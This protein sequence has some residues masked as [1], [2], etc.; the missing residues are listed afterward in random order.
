LRTTFSLPLQGLTLSGY[1]K[2]QTSWPRDGS[3]GAV[4]VVLTNNTGGA[5]DLGSGTVSV[6]LS[7]VDL[8]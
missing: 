8:R 1:V 6:A 7:S 2:T 3:N 5:V 4:T